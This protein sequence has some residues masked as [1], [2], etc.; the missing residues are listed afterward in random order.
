MVS[1]SLDPAVF[2][3]FFLGATRALA[4]LAVCPP[5]NS[6]MIPLPVK[7]GL[8]SAL[9]LVV[10]V[11]LAPTVRSVSFDTSSLVGAITIQVLAGL[12]LGFVAQLLFSALAAAGSLVDLFGGFTVAQA[13]DPFLNAQTSIF[14]RFYDLLMITLLF[15]ID[16]HLLLIRGFLTS[17]S[18]IPLQ[19]PALNRLGA[20]LTHDLSLFFLSALEVAAPLVAAL[21]VAQIVLGLLSRA[22]PSMNIFAVSFPFTVL[23]TI[24]LAGLALPLIPGVVRTL[25]NDVLQRLALF[26]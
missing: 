22:A 14:G 25:L 11:P 2:L 6:R 23:V 21:F 20:L 7:T 1:L 8:A 13:Y 10:A 5:F 26:K 16:G 17:F 19:G 15:A 18:A 3:A 9:A 12:A 24:V 4:W